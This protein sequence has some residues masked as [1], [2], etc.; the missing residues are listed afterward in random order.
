MRVHMFMCLRV[1][2]CVCMS[3]RVWVRKRERESDKREE[4][5]CKAVLKPADPHIYAT[6]SPTTKY[7]GLGTHLYVFF[8]VQP[9]VFVVF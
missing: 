3:V 7:L 4:G 8:N 1:C 6:F 9:S 5:S 2:G